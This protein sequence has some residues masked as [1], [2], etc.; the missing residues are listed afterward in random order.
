MTVGEFD[1]VFHV[2]A[3]I[4]LADLLCLFLDEGGERIDAASDVLPGLLLGGDQSVIEAFDLFA[5]SLI[6]IVQREML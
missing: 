6:D 4:L 2:V 5:L 3:V 1:R